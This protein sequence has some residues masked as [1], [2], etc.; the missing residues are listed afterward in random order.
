MAWH[1]LTTTGLIRCLTPSGPQ[2]AA[3]SK[4]PP[5]PHLQ[6][7]LQSSPT[8]IGTLSPLTPSAFYHRESAADSQSSSF[9]SNRRPSAESPRHPIA[10]PSQTAYRQL[11]SSD[12]ST[13]F[14]NTGVTSHHLDL[15]HV[16]QPPCTT[17]RN[18]APATAPGSLPLE[19]S[20]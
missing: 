7:L 12:P 9:S 6:L 14:D 13:R 15:P 3:I 18:H 10:L 16:S 8:T 11:H 5:Y 20:S 17:Y 4:A 1:G 2:Q 19:R